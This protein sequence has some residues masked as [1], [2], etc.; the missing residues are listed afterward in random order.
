MD[1]SRFGLREDTTFMIGSKAQLLTHSTH[2][3]KYC[4]LHW[5]ENSYSDL[6]YH[7]TILKII[8]KIHLIYSVVYICI[9]EICHVSYPVIKNNNSALFYFITRPWYPTSN[10]QRITNSILQSISLTLPLIV[11]LVWT[12]YIPKYPMDGYMLLLHISPALPPHAMHIGLSLMHASVYYL[13]T[14]DDYARSACTTYTQSEAPLLQLTNCCCC[15]FASSLSPSSLVAVIQLS[16]LG[17]D[18]WHALFI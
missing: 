1:K 3:Q 12:T 7:F 18:D 16:F 5:Y 10:K 11:P 14:W 6:N 9:Y 4:L 13:G 15:S 8:L 2:R 17:M